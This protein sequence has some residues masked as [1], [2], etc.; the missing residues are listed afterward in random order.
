MTTTEH[1]PAPD[2]QQAP[3]GPATGPTVTEPPAG[4]DVA[5]AGQDT[6][7]EH[8]AGPDDETDADASGRGNKEAA[9]YRRQLRDT[10][11][12]RDTLRS[13][14]DAARWQ[15]LEPTG[16]AE[17]ISVEVMRKL[18]HTVDEFVRDDGT[19]D[20]DAYQATARALAEDLGVALPM[21]TYVPTEGAGKRHLAPDARQ[22]FVNALARGRD[23]D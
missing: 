21:G 23:D 14:L 5:T 2:E 22:S 17:Q 1:T 8:A 12:E 3:Q 13:Q 10:E 11:A 6:T 19:V 16:K 20:H 7:Q 15:L 4:P 18:G 9:K